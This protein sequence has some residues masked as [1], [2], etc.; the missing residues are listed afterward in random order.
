MEYLERE[1]VEKQRYLLPRP[2]LPPLSLAMA[3]ATERE[4]KGLPVVDFSSGNVGK[5]PL[6]KTLFRKVEIEVDDGLSG[7]LRLIA[8]AIKKG[9]LASFY[10]SPKGLGYSPTGGSDAI[11]EP[12]IRYF[13]EVHAVPLKE[14]DADRVIVT[15]GGQQSMMASIR[16]LKPGTRVFLSRWDYSFISGILKEHGLAESRV[17]ADSDLSLKREEL[18]ENVTEESVF[19]ISMPN[20][21]TGYVSPSDLKFITETMVDKDGGVIWD[22]PYVFTILR[23]SHDKATFDRAFL[24]ERIEEFKKITQRHYEDMCILS[25]ISKTCLLAGLRFGFATAS[26]DWISIMNSIIGREALSSPTPLFTIGSQA[27]AMFLEHPITHEWL[28]EVLANRLT[29]LIE[30]DLP[31]ILPNNGMF[32]ALYTLVNTGGVDGTKFAT[33]LVEKH[34]IVTVTGEPFY[35]G[36]VNAIR[37]SLVAT[38]WIEDDAEFVKSVKILKKA[39]NLL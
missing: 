4:L 31:L 28:C 34:G 8:E 24:K 35:G 6:N 18:E 39:L 2:P 37:L 21:P 36:P 9:L 7:G 15:A 25:S 32:G 20:N 30:E 19:Y 29:M 17:D 38:P 27:L 33:E 13:N 5:L 22:A 10:P 14:D 11:K 12:V 23:L 16:S 1:C 26:S 3:K